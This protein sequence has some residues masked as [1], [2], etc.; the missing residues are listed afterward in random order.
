MLWDEKR[1]RVLLRDGRSVVSPWTFAKMTIKGED[2]SSLFVL[3]GHDADNY[4]LMYQTHKASEVEEVDIHPKS[5][6]HTEEQLDE[7][8]G[9]I[10]SSPRFR[11]DMI[12][13]V[14]K[15]IEFFERTNNITFLLQCIDLVA[16]MK[17]DNVVWGVGRGSSCASLVM[18]LIEVNDINPLL[19]DI[20]FSEFSKEQESKYG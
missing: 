5:H 13:R 4:D 8:V 15:E 10:V 1:Q 12:D 19:Y 14:E 20:P 3:D 18:Y 17:E 11:D 6:L 2:T 16:R 7:A 9:L